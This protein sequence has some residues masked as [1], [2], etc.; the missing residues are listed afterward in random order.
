MQFSKSKLLNS[1]DRYTDR[2][3]LYNN[4]NSIFSDSISGSFCLNNKPQQ[5]EPSVSAPI[6]ARVQLD[7]QRT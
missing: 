4:R 2:P 3:T 7:D 5:K 1:S 6:V